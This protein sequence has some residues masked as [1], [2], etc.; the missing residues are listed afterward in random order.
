MRVARA[1]TILM[2]AP[3]SGDPGWVAG[4]DFRRTSAI[5]ELETDDG[6]QGLGE[7]LAGYFIPEAVAPLVEY[8]AA[9]L[10]DP[11]LGLDPTHPLDC[12]AELYQRSLWWGRVGLAVTVLSA[13]EIAL[14]DIAGKVAGQ[15][16]HALLGGAV[17][18]RLPVYASGGT[19]TW[20]VERAVEQVAGY[21]DLGFRAVKVGTGFLHRPGGI[22]TTR[23]S[24]YG[25][26]YAGT[27]EERIADE[28]A[29]F[30]ALR[31]AFGP[32]L[33]I[34]VDSHAVQVREP[35]SR[36]TALDIA[37]AIEPYAPL[38]Y[39][40][41]LR[42]DDPAGYAWLRSRTQVPIVGG[43]CLTWPEFRQYFE[44]D[45]LDAAQ[46]DASHAGGIGAVRRIAAAAAERSAGLIVHTGGSVGPG[47]AANL[48]AA[49]ASPNAQY[50]E[51]ALAPGNVREA[52]LLEPLTL[53]DGMVRPPTAP[54]LG[55][56][57]PED[58]TERWPYQPGWHEYA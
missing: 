4:S 53:E 18:E 37:T 16:V 35:W 2:T 43:E 32:G 9:L 34:A 47:F 57:L 51:L 22:T 56:V 25:T 45:A 14:W 42:Y 55:V 10:A 17:H 13:I 46:P 49:F 36:S 41:P 58:L 5:I 40:E 44:L 33:D 8:Y 12:V 48:H 21:V 27:K 28:A 31:D 38:F 1:R 26:W 54:G 3:W 19:T 24:P 20:P 50:V 52:F 11:A 23:P 30:E 6:V 39:E 29:K 15:P 7:T